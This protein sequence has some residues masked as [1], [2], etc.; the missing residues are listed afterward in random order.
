MRASFLLIL[1]VFVGSFS[2]G[3]KIQHAFEALQEYNYFQAK[4]LF[5]KSEKKE[6]SI[7]SYGLS[8]IYYRKDNPFHNLDSAYSKI[9]ISEAT[10][11]TIKERDRI[12]Y[13]DFSFDYAAILSFREQ[14]S[15][16]LYE[17]AVERSTEADF[18]LFL[19][20]NYW[21]KEYNKAIIKRD[22]L[23]FETTQR[24]DNSVDY[25]QFLD[26]YPH[27]LYDELATEL[28]FRRQ[29]EEETKSETLE[30]YALFVKN[31]PEN[32][33]N[34]DAQDIVFKM[35]SASNSVQA[36]DDFIKKYP[37]NRNVEQAWRMLYRSYMKDF[38][39]QQLEK[40]Q[41]DFPEYPFQEELLAEK[42][43]MNQLFLPYKSDEKWGFINQSGT[44]VIPAGFDGVDF[45]H[46]GIAVVSLND[47]LGYINKSG[48]T[49][50][51]PQFDEANAF[52]NG[53]AVFQKDNGYGLLDR[54]GVVLLDPIYKDISLCSENLFFAMKDSLYACYSVDSKQVLAPA[55]TEVTSFEKGKAIVARNSGW[56]VID[57]LGKPVIDF[58][59]D[60]IQ[61]VA[62]NYLATKDAKTVIFSHFGDTL[63]A[64]DSI[65]IGAFS[66]GFALIVKN[67][68]IGVINQNA[69]M[70]VK[71]TFDNYS[72]ALIFG[73]F[74]YGHAKM[75]DAASNKFGLIDTLGNWTVLPKF[76]N[77][78]FY[79][80]IF[81][82][83]KSTYW[84]YWTTNLKK[85]WEIKFANAESFI[86]PSAVVI[87]DGKYGL[88]GKDGKFILP[89]V[90]NEIIDIHPALFRLKDSLG[91]VISDKFGN[92]KIDK[93]F[94]RIEVVMDNVLRLLKGDQIFYYFINEDKVL[95][96]EGG[97]IE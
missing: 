89:A 67:N 73:L 4:K 8:I 75:Y 76:S 69:K 65:Q 3:G 44:I 88:L 9:I 28:F 64:A 79:S 1:F 41:T 31:H 68:K 2:Y 91:F 37:G 80:S 72:N 12:K 40:F 59:Y 7:A 82:A 63:F 60:H 53:V 86:G 19:K 25:R 78:S 57:T 93:H 77:I 36:Y 50:I 6:K 51:K 87:N 85:K 30:S 70:V 21:A 96:A 26:K 22:S 92:Q 95:A 34:A 66:E 29:Y 58:Q 23:A 49:V 33:Y 97:Q 38:S 61:T 71:Y 90:W 13:A 10:Y 94:D 74:K 54:S 15:S 14:I 5:E 45:F 47:K 55:F 32:P 35:A 62:Q 84:E 83:Q 42:E 20:N 16:A 81:A 18:V 39:K 24:L 46:E 56:G 52:S 17:R 43:R 27:S 48:N 11:T